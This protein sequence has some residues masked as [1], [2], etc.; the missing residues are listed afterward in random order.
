MNSFESWIAPLRPFYTQTIDFLPRFALALLVLA[1]GWLVAR[2]VRF[3]VVRGLR[4]VNFHVLTERSGM[5]AVLRQGGV[6]RDTSAIV[7]LLVFW[8]VLVAALVAAFNALGL[9]YVTALLH[10]VALFI[11]RILV[12]VLVLVLGAYFARFLGAT[13]ATFCRN[14]GIQD[15]A[16]IGRL[17]H[18][19]VLGFVILIALDQVNIRGDLVRLTFLV[20]LAGIVFALA[21]AFGIGGSQWAAEVLERWW[22]RQ[23]SDEQPRAVPPS[24]PRSRDA[25]LP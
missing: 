12:A 22:P 21:L 14:A 10:E 11:P 23:R 13:A 25:P 9:V 19:A 4:A 16:P 8:L 24:Q 20:L 18:Y 15:S 5:D 7:G 1:A 6:E 17:V 2:V 3:A